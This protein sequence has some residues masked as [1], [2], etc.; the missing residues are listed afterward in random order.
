MQMINSV[1]NKQVVNPII[2]IEPIYQFYADFRGHKE[3][4][5]DDRRE[6]KQSIEIFLEHLRTKQLIK[7]YARV[8]K[9]G[10][11]TSYKIAVYSNRDK[12]ELKDKN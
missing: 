6:A 12:R 3:P 8:Q 1:N 11:V 2:N 10:K 4:T 5:D 7:S 9:T